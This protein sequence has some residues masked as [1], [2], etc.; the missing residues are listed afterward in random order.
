MSIA[1]DDSQPF[2]Y[3]FH[4]DVLRFSTFG[5]EDAPLYQFGDNVHYFGMT[6]STDYDYPKFLDI[7][8]NQLQIDDSSGAVG[9]GDPAYLVP[10]DITGAPRTSPPDAGAYQHAPFPESD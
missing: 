5:F 6:L 2:E 4:N 8:K 10:G 7:S 3:Q 1:K 9:K